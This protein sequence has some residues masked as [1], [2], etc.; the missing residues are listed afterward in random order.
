M[1]ELQVPPAQRSI[2]RSLERD[3]GSVLHDIGRLVTSM[4]ASRD[5]QPVQLL[6][7]PPAVRAPA[8]LGSR[9]SQAATV[10]HGAAANSKG[11]SIWESPLIVAA[12]GLF[13]IKSA[14][15]ATA[16]ERDGAAARQRMSLAAQGGKKLLRSR[17]DPLFPISAEVDR[18]DGGRTQMA[19]G[20]HKMLPGWQEAAIQ[21][22]ALRREST[23]DNLGQALR[24]HDARMLKDSTGFSAGDLA[25]LEHDAAVEERKD[26]T[27]SGGKTTAAAP[28]SAVAAAPS[29]S[30]SPWEEAS[31]QQ[32]LLRHESVEANLREALSAREVRLL[33]KKAGWQSEDELAKAERFAENLQRAIAS[34]RREER[35]H[36]LIPSEARTALRRTEG[37]RVV[38][39]KREKK[40][41]MEWQVVHNDEVQAVQRIREEQPVVKAYQAQVRS[42]PRPSPWHLVVSTMAFQQPKGC[43]VLCF[44]RPVARPHPASPRSGI[45]RDGQVPLLLS[46]MGASGLV[47]NLNHLLTSSCRRQVKND[48][49]EFEDEVKEQNETLERLQRDQAKLAAAVKKQGSEGHAAK[50][51]AEKVKRTMT[52]L[53]QSHRAASAVSA[54]VAE[55]AQPRGV[56][57][58]KQ[59][60]QDL[61]AY[62]KSL[63]Q[64]TRAESGTKRAVKAA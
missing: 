31:I 45:E 59:A 60:N 57:S 32:G 8:H 18:V 5:P 24:E 58:S 44:A 27:P 42:P 48:E 13:G 6:S 35:K 56:M 52:T 33:E 22:G 17:K 10:V 63:A 14:S 38:Q 51:A 15:V 54:A 16:A 19:R 61:D 47:F 23:R 49:Q 46:A 4:F 55:S 41:S 62:F 53:V 11:V 21:K 34:R 1:C 36:P 20:A 25:A 43:N 9:K 3:S 29:K 2:L 12:K 26:A 28:A 7:V 64:Q 30:V 39:T 37:T 50:Q 40:L